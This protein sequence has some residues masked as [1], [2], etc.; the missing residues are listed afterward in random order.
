MNRKIKILCIDPS[1]RN[2]ALV[3][4]EV[5]PDTLKAEA[6]FSTTISTEKSRSKQIRASSDLIQR[7]RQLH[8]EAMDILNIF[9]PDLIFAETPAGSQNA[10][11]MKAYALSCYLLG[12]LNPEPIEVTPIE[13]KKATVGT[14]TASKVEMIAW[15]F[16]KHPEVNWKLD[17]SGHPQIST[18]EH[19]ADAVAVLYAGMKTSD[20]SRALS[21]WK[22]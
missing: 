6:V 19:K 18:E 15:A 17:K 3:L 16:E 2:T 20:F 12:T 21:M 4:F 22:K 14:K 5:C 1:M 10:N 13:V 9:P 11:G 7:C 8:K